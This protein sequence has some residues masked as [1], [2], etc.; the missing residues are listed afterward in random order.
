V[1]SN[2]VSCHNGGV[3][4]GKNPGHITSTASC[5]DCHNTRDWIPVVRVDHGSVI[6]TCFSC[7][8]GVI[9]RG[10]GPQHDPPPTSNDCELC[11][12]VLGWIPATP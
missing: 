2:C 5:E 4:E 8:N 7:H 9:A 1:T 3:A 12:S 11:H 6:G 10:K